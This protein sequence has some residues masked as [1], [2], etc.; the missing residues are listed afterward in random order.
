L[1]S[2]CRPVVPGLPP[3]R[4]ISRSALLIL[5]GRLPISMRIHLLHPAG[6]NLP[7]PVRALR[8]PSCF[9]AEGR[10]PNPI[11]P[12]SSATIPGRPFPTWSMYAAC[13]EAGRQRPSSGRPVALTAAP[14]RQEAAIASAQEAPHRQGAT[15]SEQQRSEQSRRPVICGNWARRRIGGWQRVS[16]VRHGQPLRSPRRITPALIRP[17]TALIERIAGSV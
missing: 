10:P 11:R 13:D 9:Q 6:L 4:A 7:R 1:P 16:A 8:R 5:S 3:H 12:S 14:A 2:S 17:T 15:Q